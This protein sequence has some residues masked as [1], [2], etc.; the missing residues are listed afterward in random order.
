MKITCIFLCLKVLFF[1]YATTGFYENKL[2]KTR[3]LRFAL[4]PFN[5]AENVAFE[6]TL[7]L[8]H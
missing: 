2:I 8:V 5:I 6:E 7:I 3:R 1:K 4:K